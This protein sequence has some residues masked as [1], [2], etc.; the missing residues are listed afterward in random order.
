MAIQGLK[1][2][3]SMFKKVLASVSKQYGYNCCVLEFG[4][5]NQCLKLTTSQC[6]PRVSVATSS[7]KQKIVFMVSTITIVTGIMEMGI[8]LFGLH[9][10]AIKG[11]CIITMKLFSSIANKL[12]SGSDKSMVLNSIYLFCI[13]LVSREK[14]DI[15]LILNR[16]LCH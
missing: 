2:E 13:F 14:F 9:T 15:Y 3:T 16:N 7:K 5:V 10:S 8:Y 6:L 1:F 11:K 12:F 4:S